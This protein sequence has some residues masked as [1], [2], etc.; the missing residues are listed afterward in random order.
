PEPSSLANQISPLEA[1]PAGTAERACAGAQGPA[2]DSQERR[3]YL[4]RAV[5]RC[6]AVGTSV[7]NASDPRAA[8][9][10]CLLTRK[11]SCSVRL[12]VERAASSPNTAA[13]SRLI[14][15]RISVAGIASTF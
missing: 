6:V 8:S 15:S 14:P 10:A 3:E 12:G 4:R 2:K 7:A 11:A 9:S 1:H 5:R 13:I